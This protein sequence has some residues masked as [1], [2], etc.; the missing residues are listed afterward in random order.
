MIDQNQQT[1]NAPPT[2]TDHRSVGDHLDR[3]LPT[4]GADPDPV[5]SEDHTI[6]LALPSEIEHDRAVDGPIE[7]SDVGGGDGAGP[8]RW[9]ARRAASIMAVICRLRS[10]SSAFELGELPIGADAG[11][12]EVFG[13]VL[14]LLL[15]RLV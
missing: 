7:Q 10:A 2:D 3:A 5:V 14:A 11:L 12:L 8:G 4:G 15:A 6:R 1:E 13:V 9:S